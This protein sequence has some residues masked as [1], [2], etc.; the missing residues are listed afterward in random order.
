MAGVDWRKVVNLLATL[1][2]VCRTCV[3]EAMVVR[4]SRRMQEGSLSVCGI[5]SSAFNV[6]RNLHLCGGGC[7]FALL[8][9]TVEDLH[10]GVGGMREKVVFVG[11]C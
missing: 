5:K 7:V 9:T 8:G 10:H 3:N 4:V 6:G 11:L 1:S 2:V